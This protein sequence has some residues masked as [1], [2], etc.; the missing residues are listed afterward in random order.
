[1]D[2]VARLIEIEAIKEIRQMYSHYF[3]GRRID[4]LVDL[5]TEDAVCEFGAVFGG[6]WVGRA[7]IHTNFARYASAEGPQHGVMHAVTNP[8]IDRKSTRLN[9]SH[10]GISRMPS[11]A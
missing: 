3:D 1:M 11:S 8:W 7:Q 4:E 2:A 10:G 6:D 5:F 9:S